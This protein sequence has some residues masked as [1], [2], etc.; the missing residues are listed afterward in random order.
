MMRQQRRFRYG[1]GDGL[2]VLELPY[3]GD[4][5]AMFIL[6]PDQVDGLAAIE[7]ALT[8]KQLTQWLNNLQERDVE[9]F[10]PQFKISH[11]FKLNETLKTMGIVDAF[12]ERHA[13][14]AGMDGNDQWLYI[15]AVL[16]KAFI[17]VNEEGTEAAAATAVVMKAR[18]MPMPTPIFRADHPFIFLICEKSTGSIL[19]LGR[20]VHP[21][22][23][24][25]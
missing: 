12:D 6:L 8:L 9:V 21:Q 11:S 7:S 10:L 22:R 18:S 14:F 1:A 5:L 25:L 13:N 23:E 3:A 24:S 15:T 17:D 20:V 19:L 16:H 2:Q 4:A